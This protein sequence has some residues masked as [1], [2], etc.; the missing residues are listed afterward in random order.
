MSVLKNEVNRILKNIK[1]GKNADF[2]VL[3]SVTYNHLKI[4]ALNYLANSSDVDDVIN[5]AYLRVFSYI[6]SANTDMDGYNWLCKIVQNIAYDYNKKSNIDFPINRVETNSLF[7]E[8]DEHVSDNLQI[9]SAMKKLDGL[10]QELIYLKFWEDLS[11]AEIAKKKSLKKPTVYKK[12]KR[13]LKILK[14]IFED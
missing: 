1:N 2:E 9:I 3:H 11:Y 7:Y 4:V 14:Q 13:A 5:E 8:I 12:T 10:E 6:R